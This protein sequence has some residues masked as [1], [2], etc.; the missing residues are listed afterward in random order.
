MSGALRFSILMVIFA[1][2]L[3]VVFLP[4]RLAVEWSS[5]EE[6]GVSA[7]DIQGSIWSGALMEVR[8]R[9]IPLGSFD[10][11]L[12]PASLVS[13]PMVAISR[14]DG[15]EH[16]AAGQPFSAMVGG[17]TG[18]LVVSDASGDIALDQVAGK[19]PVSA[20]RLNNVAITMDEG[21][22]VEASGDVQ[23]VLSAWL[24]RFA[25]Q[26][27][28]RGALSCNGDAL[29]ALVKGQSGLESFTFQLQP[30]GQY[31]AQLRIEGL[32]SELSLGLV[33]L[34]FGKSGNAMVLGTEG[35]LR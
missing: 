17:S 14:P 26:N 22:C 18:R 2:G 33:A 29:Q 11:A 31:S 34:G 35:V 27:G 1:M 3:A 19:L 7:R 12:Q 25:A 9:D 15:P 21:R 30:G 8:F 13:T 6:R 20:A 24:G 4:M 23:L 28:L 5:L 16:S 32:S 10:A